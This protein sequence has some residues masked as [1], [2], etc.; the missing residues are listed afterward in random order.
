MAAFAKVL[1]CEWNGFKSM[2]L[3]LNGAYQ[4]VLTWVYWMLYFF[5]G[6]HQRCGAVQSS[7]ELGCWG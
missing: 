3:E 1:K 7:G 2:D 5:A 6:D 4:L